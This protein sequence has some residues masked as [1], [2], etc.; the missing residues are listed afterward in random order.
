MAR[1]ACGMLSLRLLRW[2]CDDTVRMAAVRQANVFDKLV[3]N[4]RLRNWQL[5]ASWPKP[6]Y[7]SVSVACLHPHLSLTQTIPKNIPACR[8]TGLN[9]LASFSSLE[10]DM[11]KSL[12]INYVVG[13][14]DNHF[15]AVQIPEQTVRPC[16]VYVVEQ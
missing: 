9:R 4:H 13:T 11:R 3:F 8:L 10:I 15:Y 16:W 14:I 7:Y 12:R 5:I 2:S 6:K 1:M